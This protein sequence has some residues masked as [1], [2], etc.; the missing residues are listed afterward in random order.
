MADHPEV[1]SH[2]DA[3]DNRSLKEIIED[4]LLGFEHIIQAH[5]RLARTEIAQKA[6]PVRYAAVFLGIAALCGGLGAACFVL[7]SIAA[8][9][10]VMPLWLAALLIGIGLFCVA[11]GAFVMGRTRLQQIDAAP[12][13]TVETIKDDLQWAKHHMS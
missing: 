2:T 10:L 3:V 7:T 13:Q 6:G 8:M 12:H 11:G 1:Q 9:T 5:L 4:I